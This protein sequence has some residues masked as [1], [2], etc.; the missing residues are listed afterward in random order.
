M[1]RD[2]DLIDAD[3]ACLRT[4]RLPATLI[5]TRGYHC[6]VW[7]T[8]GTLHR[9]NRR[10]RLDLVIKVHREACS[11]AEV[12]VLGREHQRLRAALGIIAP[13]TRFV[14]TCINGRP[15][16]VALA[17]AVSRWFDVANP[18]H[19]S[20]AVP[21]FRRLPQARRE[22][23]IFLRA[24]ERW[25]EEEDRVVDLYGL[26]NLVLDVNH[27]V[28]YIDSFRVFMYADLLHAMAEPDDTLQH[29]VDISRQR[30]AYLHHLLSES[31][32]A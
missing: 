20:E 14:V 7:R 22:L 27:R 5:S 23:G 10:I 26:D 30:R 29:R 1:S 28:R 2:N 32:A 16:V 3:I 21:L 15:S 31:G 11:L 8:S 24:A 25:D 12:R 18:I 9:G 4:R 17:P 19:E 13:P 6:T